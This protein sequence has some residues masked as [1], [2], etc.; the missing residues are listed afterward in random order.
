MTR[1]PTSPK[2]LRCPI[3]RDEAWVEQG[4]TWGAWYAAC[5]TGDGGHIVDAKGDT[6]DDLIKNWNAEV[7][8]IKA[9]IDQ[10]KRAEENKILAKANA[11][12]ARRNR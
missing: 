7:R 6:Q 10:E 5:Y 1:V 9:E 11:I 3:C 4:G 12:R 2:M 8:R